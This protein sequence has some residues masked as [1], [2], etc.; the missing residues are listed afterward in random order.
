MRQSTILIIGLIF[1]QLL[2]FTSKANSS[3]CIKR[4][5]AKSNKML[6]SKNHTQYKNK[7]KLEKRNSGKINW[8]EINK[9]DK[10]VVIKT[11]NLETPPRFY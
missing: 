6:K 5:S 9:S 8:A 3:N 11:R 10:K 2:S 1:L 4:T 7:R